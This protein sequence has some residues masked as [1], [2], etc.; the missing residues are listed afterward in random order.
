MKEIIAGF[1]WFVTATPNE[2]KNRHFNSEMD[3]R[4]NYW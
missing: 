2:I 1:Y 4:K 3:L